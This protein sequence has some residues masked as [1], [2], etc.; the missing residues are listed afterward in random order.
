MNNSAIVPSI[1]IYRQHIS[2]WYSET[3]VFGLTF[4]HVGLARGQNN[5]S[6]I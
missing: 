1:R 3:G 5:G 6:H 2:N 4:Q